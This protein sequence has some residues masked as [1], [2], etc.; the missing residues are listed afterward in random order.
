MPHDPIPALLFQA[1]VTRLIEEPIYKPTSEP[2]YKPLGNIDTR[3]VD[4]PI[5][6][7]KDESIE[8]SND[9]H[10][11]AHTAQP[12][13]DYIAESVTEHI[14]E[15]V[16]EPIN[17][18][19]N[20]PIYKPC[21]EADA[22]PVNE[23][24]NE[25]I[26]ESIDEPSEESIDA[27]IDTHTAQVIAEPITEPIG[28]PTVEPVAESDHDNNILTAT[29]NLPPTDQKPSKP[30]KKKRK[31]KP[32]PQQKSSR[33]EFC[34][35]NVDDDESPW[36]KGRNAI[37]SFLAEGKP[38]KAC[39]IGFIMLREIRRASEVKDYQC[40]PTPQ[41]LTL[42]YM[43]L[44]RA[45]LEV[46]DWSSGFSDVERAWEYSEGGALLSGKERKRLQKLMRKVLEARASGEG[47]IADLGEGEGEKR[48]LLAEDEE[49]IDS[50]SVGLMEG[51][52]G[53]EDFW[54]REG[55]VY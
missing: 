40:P 17:E 13:A 20:E 32:Q 39:V 25:S 3:P 11:D 37:R 4:E 35:P 44:A 19:T 31:K 2:I 23:L 53:E 42:V 36:I 24:I 50:L 43:E 54:G 45:R 46:G 51:I 34:F 8:E 52:E 47:W 12:T 21:D 9:R 30:R 5:S 26:D 1:A 28:E 15:P 18:S 27:R 55:S 33:V 14:D 48:E 29:T 22:G 41:E 38:C 6:Q 7:P 16:D 49:F 10:I